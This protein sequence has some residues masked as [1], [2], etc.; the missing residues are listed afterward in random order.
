MQFKDLSQT[1]KRAHVE[2]SFRAA[3]VDLDRL[4]PGAR[5]LH[6]HKRVAGFLNM[7]C[8]G[9]R[10]DMREL[11]AQWAA[12]HGHHTPEAVARF[13]A[14]RTAAVPI[15]TVFAKKATIDEK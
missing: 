13:I 12:E 11:A 7:Q 2:A 5:G 10:H 14:D 8:A 6:D 3:I 4:H 9:L 1:A 15:P